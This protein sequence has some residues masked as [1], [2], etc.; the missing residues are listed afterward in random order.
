MSTCHN[1]SSEPAAAAGTLKVALVGSPNVGK[2]SVFHSLTGRRV[3]ISNYPGTTVDVFRGRTSFNGHHVEVVDTPGMYSLHSITE[4]ERVA[5]AI[6]LQEKPDVVLHVVDAK[7]LERMLP[8]TY[9]LIE[10]GLPVILVLNMMDET[11]ALGIDIDTDLLSIELG[12]PVQKTAA[13][14]GRGI[15]EL[16]QAVLNYQPVCL[17]LPVF[18]DNTI[19]QAVAALLPLVKNQPAVRK[20][21]PRA[22]ALLLLRDDT[23]ILQLLTDD[24]ADIKAIEKIISEVRASINQTPAYLLAVSQQRAA[25]QMVRKVMTQ[26]ADDKPPFREKLSRAMMHPLSGSLILAAVLMVMYFFVGVFGAGTLVGWLEEVVFGQYINPWLQDVLGN[27]IPVKIIADLF[28][29][30]YGVITLGLTYAIGIIL[31]IVS[32]FFII[33]SIIEDSGYL[34]RLAM[35][36]D[37]LFKFIGLNGRAV[38]PIVL[39]LGCDTMATIVTRTQ[40]TK[41]ERVITTLLLALAIPC[42]AQLGVIF[43]ILSVSTGMILTW[44]GVVLLVFLLVGY[45]ASR[46][47]SGER[48]S[49]YMEIPP[50][51]LPRLANVLT[52]TYARLEWYLMEVIPFFLLASVVLWAGDAVGLLDILINA[53]KPVIEFVGIP[54]EAA[55][56]FIIGFFRRDFGAAGLYDLATEGILFGNGLLVSAVVMTLFV[57]CIAQ[58]MVMIKERGW[59]TAL[60]IAGFIFPFAFLVGLVLD[61]TLKL[62]GVNL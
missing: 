38:I 55:V 30:D 26:R 48:A 35:L 16:K 3:V 9:Q 7:N 5:R 31:P 50:L 44:L 34:P 18:Y 19:E 61:R 58:F 2:S 11:Q 46:L 24:G 59:K 62:L 13:N 17:N 57:P 10:A 54:A 43:G 8:I 12:V 15:N 25:Q 32:T 45:L 39:G 20:L 37:R 36:V 47:I 1:P 52:K 23:Q 60:A 40:E 22:I 42:S 27:L 4:E 28:I 41:R 29:G 14:L 53:L 56:A 6:L 51:R 33:F 49:F 21:S